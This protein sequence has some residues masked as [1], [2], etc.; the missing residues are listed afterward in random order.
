LAAPSARAALLDIFGVRGVRGLAGFFV[1]VL[2]VISELGVGTPVAHCGGEAWP[3]RFPAT[4]RGAG[5]QPATR[6]ISLSTSW[7]IELVAAG[8]PW[9]SVP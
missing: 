9:R 6:S 3:S 4:P 2:M 5:Q 1:F 8:R 7:T